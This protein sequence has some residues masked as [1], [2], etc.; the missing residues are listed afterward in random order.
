APRTGPTRH[1]LARG[2]RVQVHSRRIAAR[3]SGSAPA[4]AERPFV[5]RPPRESR[6]VP[7]V[8]ERQRAV[9]GA[10]ASTR[11]R[12]FSGLALVFALSFVNL[13]GI[14]VTATALGG[15]APWTRWQFIGMFGVVELA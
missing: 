5:R 13:V 9:R 3:T 8:G 14:L 6:S 7:A 11:G 15:I 1:D 4:G 10:S 12:A 2:C